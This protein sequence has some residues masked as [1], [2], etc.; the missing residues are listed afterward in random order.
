MPGVM[1][2]KWS[3]LHATHIPILDD[4]HHCIVA[5]TNSIF[6]FMRNHQGSEV[7]LSFLAMLEHYMHI[8][9]LTEE[10]LLQLTNCP[11]FKGHKIKH[12]SLRTRLKIIT[13][14]TKKTF[15]PED[16]LLFLKK[17]WLEHIN[18]ADA[19]FVPHVRQTLH[20]LGKLRENIDLAIEYI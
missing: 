18:K 10:N 7:I 4:Q 2:I 14:Q 6:Y 15:E 9:F 3:D 20:K 8:H 1:L 12:D 5:I 13:A 17:I 16:T 11:D 19:H